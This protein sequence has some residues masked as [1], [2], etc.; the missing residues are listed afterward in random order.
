MTRRGGFLD[1]VADFDPGF[2]GISPPRG[3]VHGPQQ[4]L[5]LEVS[6]RP[7]NAPGSTRPRCAAP[8][9][10]RSSAPTAQD[11]AYLVVRSLADADGDV[12]TGI[13]AG[14]V[15]GR[16]SYELGLEGPAV[17]VDTACSSSLVA[18][19]QAVHALLAEECSLAL[20]GGVNVMCT[21]G[22]LLEFSRQGGLASRRRKAFSRPPS[23]HG[24]RCKAFSTA[25]AP[26]GRGRR[27][28]GAG[29]LSDAA[30]TGT[31]CWRW[32]AAPR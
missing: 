27:G 5:L 11:Y 9:P 21:P 7:S 6:W 8:A 20:A 4:R 31:R 28:A 30:A 24:G 17:T 13:A 23:A 1:G 16:L 26:L 29:A 32:C 15:S 18:V 2:F 25:T 22:A 14:A 3:A 19:H 10:A 12:G